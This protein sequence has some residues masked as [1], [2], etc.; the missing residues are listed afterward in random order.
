[1]HKEFTIFIMILNTFIYRMYFF[2]IPINAAR[3]FQIMKKLFYEN[4]GIVAK[5]SIH[6]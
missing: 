6:A 1:M 3:D 5:E 4:S 2:K